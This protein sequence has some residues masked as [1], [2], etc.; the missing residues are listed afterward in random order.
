MSVALYGHFR[1]EAS[2]VQVTRGLQRALIRADLLDGVVG[3][4]LEDVDEAAAVTSPVSLNCGDPR[5]LLMAHRLGDHR[6][7]WL[8]LAPNGETMPEGFV[9]AMTEPTEVCPAGLL[10]GGILTPSVWG[11]AVLR[12]YFPKHEVIV[13]RHGVM[14]EIHYVREAQRA[15]TRRQYD[16]GLFYAVHFVSGETERKGT[17]VL[18]EAWHV[19]KYLKRALPRRAAL[20]LVV[21]PPEMSRIR[22]KALKLGLDADDGSDD[23]LIVPGFSLTQ[24]EVVETYYSAAHVV[25]QPSRGE[26]FGMVPVEARACGVPVVATGCTGHSEHMP[27]LVGPALSGCVLVKTGPSEPMDDFPGSTAPSLRV[28]DVADAL[29][30][31]YEDWR[32]IDDAA[33][34]L[35]ENIQAEWTWERGAAQALARLKERGEQNVR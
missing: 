21:P 16:E 26:G 11:A 23:L 18:L 17:G 33:R 25:C 1:G 14:P 3:I 30:H 10:D 35:A 15:R 4:D 8:M 31:A 24:N 28:E 7:H 29:Q 19:L 34:G 9:T 32:R 2:F 22:W 6:E 13:A 5:A 27:R 20:I 12:R